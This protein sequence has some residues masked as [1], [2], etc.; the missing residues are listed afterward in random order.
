MLFIGGSSK[1]PYIQNALSEYFEESE[2][3]IPNNLQTHVSKGA[4]IHSLI[5]NG[6]GKNIIQP[7]T[8]EPIIVVTKSGNQRVLIPAG[9]Q[10]PCEKITID[11]L[12]TNRDGQDVIELPI[13]VGNSNKMLFNIKINLPASQIKKGER[14]TL[15]I[16]YTADKLLKTEAFCHGVK[17]APEQLDP[18]AN[19]ELSSGERAIIL[20]EREV[21]RSASANGGTPS[22]DAL[23]KLIDAYYN[24]GNEYMAAET[25]EIKEDFYPGSVDFNDVG[26]MYSS[27]GNKL[28]A[29]SAYE[30][31]LS[32]N[33]GNATV[34]V[35]LSMAY[36]WHD[37][38]KFKEY[39][40][41]AY[42]M[43]PGDPVILINMSRAES[44][45]EKAAMLKKQ[46]YDIYLD[47][48]K[49]NR[50]NPWDYSWFASLAGELGHYDIARKVRAAQPGSN[51][52]RSLYNEEN[53]A[54]S[55]NKQL[56]NR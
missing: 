1:N 56:Q 48:F 5:I 45:N 6:F 34:C 55:S 42:E 43:S 10:I 31:A 4:A 24:A 3:L 41:K 37:N 27:S 33:S 11:D 39:A 13:C 51:N 32:K 36:R 53:L 46:A 7:I 25:S 35:N 21:D 38:Q 17:V 20:A 22:K 15:T 26:L 54:N 47:K 18:F 16:E 2:L 14:V 44:D 28:K 40:Q 49:S 30:R 12:E 29:I 50:M 19:K 9:A 8:S 23:T 52:V